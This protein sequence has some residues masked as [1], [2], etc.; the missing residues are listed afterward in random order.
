MHNTAHNTSLM[1]TPLT[2]E[3]IIVIFKSEKTRFP[4]LKMKND[5]TEIY[6]LRE[7]QSSAYAKIVY[8]LE[9]KENKKQT[10]RK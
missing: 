9:Q 7:R 2:A 1:S 5:S 10:K 3:S 4:V 6:G 8:L